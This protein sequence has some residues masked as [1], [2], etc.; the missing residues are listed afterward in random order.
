MCQ[1][2]AFMLE[3]YFLLGGFEEKVKKIMDYL[4]ANLDGMEPR[5]ELGEVL[6]VL[7]QVSAREKEFEKQAKKMYA[8][9]EGMSVKLDD[10]FELNW[11]SQFLEKSNIKN[12][13]LHAAKIWEILQKILTKVSNNIETNYLAVIYECLSSLGKIL[14]EEGIRD[15]RFEYF[16]KL[17]SRRGEWGLYYFRGMQVAR[18]D[19]TGHV[20]FN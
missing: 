7:A 18:M 12:K 8:R 9:F 13:K 2:S 5:F 16:I 15:D 11:Q 19:I 20:I 4:Y 17:N 6:M 10:V 3:D 14:S 1:A